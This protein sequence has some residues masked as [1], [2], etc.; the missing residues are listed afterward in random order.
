MFI[1]T[2]GTLIDSS[3]PL[4]PSTQSISC[5]T[6]IFLHL[7]CHYSRY[8][9]PRLLH[10]PSPWSCQDPVVPHPKAAEVPAHVSSQAWNL[11]MASHYLCIKSK[12]A[13]SR[14]HLPR[15]WSQLVL[16]SSLSLLSTFTA[17]IIFWNR[18][19]SGQQVFVWLLA[20]VSLRCSSFTVT[21]S[22]STE[23]SEVSPP[24]H[25]LKSHHLILFSLFLNLQSLSWPGIMFCICFLCLPACLLNWAQYLPVL[26]PLYL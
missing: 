6:S 21:S 9:V 15:L 26:C 4:I 20:L 18:S 2:L 25:F 1:E 22:D 8:F 3:D 10:W 13:L 5:C 19:S 23:S 12:L 17:L 14:T 7:H 24:C 16:L 11:P